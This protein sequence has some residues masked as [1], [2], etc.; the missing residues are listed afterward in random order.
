[1]WDPGLCFEQVASRQLGI[2]PLR[3][4][5]PLPSRARCCPSTSLRFSFPRRIHH[6]TFV[7][8]P[9]Y[10]SITLTYFL[11]RFFNFHCPYTSLFLRLC[12][13]THLSQHPNFRHTQR[14]LLRCITFFLAH[15][16]PPPPH[17]PNCR[18]SYCNYNCSNTK[19]LS[20]VDVPK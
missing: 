8:F 17:V 11:G 4:I 10:V 5:I 6:P 16:L 19:R 7:L 15:V 2:A 12:N 3:P 18:P 9:L 1:M 14:L 13:S 20:L